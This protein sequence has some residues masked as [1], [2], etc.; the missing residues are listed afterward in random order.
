MLTSFLWKFG[1]IVTSQIFFFFF[2]R[3]NVVPR[4]LIPSPPDFTG[5]W[6]KPSDV[7][8]GSLSQAL[9]D[10]RIILSMRQLCSGGHI[11]VPVHAGVLEPRSPVSPPVSDT[12]LMGPK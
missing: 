1:S 4:L 12:A 8:F 11:P 7:S 9:I 10:P 3:G 6:R 5:A 2:R